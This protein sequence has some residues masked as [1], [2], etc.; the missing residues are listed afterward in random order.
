MDE[1]T[2]FMP[3]GMP[4][5]FWEDTTSYTKVLHVACGHADASDD[6]PGTPDAPL[7]TIGRVAS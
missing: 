4:F 6:N 2:V 5:E 1:S 7:K 3:D